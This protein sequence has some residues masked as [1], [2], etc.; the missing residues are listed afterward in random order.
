MINSMQSA[1][2]GSTTWTKGIPRINKVFMILSILLVFGFDLFVII[3]Y[4]DLI[5]FWYIMLGV[6]AAFALFYALE[7]FVLRKKFAGTTS[8]LDK[9]IRLIIILRNLI[10]LLNFIPVIQLLGLALLAGV[11]TIIPVFGGGDLGLALGLGGLG[12]IAPA[13]IVLYIILVF[14]RFSGTRKQ[15]GSFS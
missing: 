4:P 9:W 7:N 8:A 15:Q 10:F 2:T 5:S 3:S 6:L 13:L 1:S 12:L 14:A 11:F